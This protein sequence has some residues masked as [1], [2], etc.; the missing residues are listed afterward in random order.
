[1]RACWTSLRKSYCC[2]LVA[3]GVAAGLLPV[4][5]ASAA[6][7]CTNQAARDQQ[8]AGYL[9]DCRAYELS[10][11][12]NKN[13]EEVEVPGQYIQEIPFAA[14]LT[15]GGIAFTLTGGIPGSESAGL[16]TAAVGHSAAPGSP[17]NTVSLNPENRFSV[18]PGPGPRNAGLFHYFS[19]DLSCGVESTRLAIARHSGE[20]PQ[21]APGENPEEG[22]ENLY[23]WDA[24]TDSYTLVTNVRPKEPQANPEG[25]GYWVDGAS[26]GCAR[27][28]FE[29]GSSGYEL[30]GAPSSSLY[31][32]SAATDKV[33]VASK[34]PD[35]TNAEI[36]P[37]DGGEFHSNL[38]MIS[39][40]GSRIFFTAPSDAGP[41]AGSNEIFVR[42]DGTTTIEASASKTGVI[43]AGA[44]FQGAS[45]DGSHVYFKANYGLTAQ[46]SVGTEAPSICEV[47]PS[48]AGRGCDLYDYNVNSGTLTDLSADVEAVTEDRK[49]G[50]ALGVFGISEQGPVVYFATT[51]R[52]LAGKGNT[53]VANE[54]V[55]AEKPFKEVN[56]YAFQAGA[57]S[58][59]TSIGQAEAGGA[60]TPEEEVDVISSNSHGLHFLVA[61][62]SDDGQRLLLATKK[63]LTGYDNTDAV[64]GKR[65]YEQYLFSLGSSVPTCVSCDPSGA[66][67]I[68]HSGSQFGPLGVFLENHDGRIPRNL[69]SDGRVYFDSF[70]LLLPQAK[71]ASVNAYEWNPAGVAG[72]ESPAGCVAILDSGTDPFPSYFEDASLDGADVYVTT[73]AQLAPQ[74][75]DGLR[76]IYDVRVNGGIL[77]TPAPPGCSGEACQGPSGAGIPA[78][79][80]NSETAIGGN[81]ATIPPP[82]PPPPPPPS[83]S[84][85]K[86]SVARRVSRAHVL[87]LVTVPGAG[88]LTVAGHGL[89]THR[90]AISK[91][92]S[93]RVRVSLTRAERNLLRRRHRLRLTVHVRFAPA[94]GQVSATTTRLT[95]R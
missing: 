69:A 57:L 95:V 58:Y 49:G 51:G 37:V 67:P 42:K 94:T 90:Q 35:G 27:I 62:V 78:A 93:V 15:G 44:Y 8:G 88:S 80:H 24:A 5:T 14:A 1:M 56:V 64:S 59:V 3:I 34:L 6:G 50:D 54:E 23:T 10:S 45:A 25:L 2:A 75:E 89:R 86:S 74:D 32:W 87:V 43:D 76:D 63:R 92:T 72:C 40:D 26:S 82:P 60:L 61:R 77:A 53:Q 52:L 29:N 22:I 11:P 84:A 70:G 38:N 81:L 55:T 41:D 20:P 83:P 46:S 9:P 31:E 17:W 85:V 33:I 91:A 48:G 66:K 4:A 12:V 30:L 16:Y 79:A 73:H 21:L 13:E 36:V 47:P 7:G 71:N 65:D 68:A 18:L 39:G 19:P 28:I